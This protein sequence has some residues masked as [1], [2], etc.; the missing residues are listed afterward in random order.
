MKKRIYMT[1]L[2]GLSVVFWYYRK[3]FLRNTAGLGNPT[4]VLEAQKPILQRLAAIPQNFVLS[5]ALSSFCDA[6]ESEEDSL[7]TQIDQFK[8]ELSSR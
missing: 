2:I 8:A 5:A 7:Q 4:F 6:F 3:Q 1:Y